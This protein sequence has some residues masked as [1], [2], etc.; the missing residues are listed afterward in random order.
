MDDPDDPY[1]PDN[2]S[3]NWRLG[4]RS[5]GRSAA[6]AGAGRA[7]HRRN[8]R[9]RRSRVRPSANRKSAPMREQ[10]GCVA[11]GVE[12]LRRRGGVPEG[13]EAGHACQDGRV[14]PATGPYFKCPRR[15]SRPTARPATMARSMTVISMARSRRDRRPR[16]PLPLP[17]VMPGG[18]LAKIADMLT[19]FLR[20]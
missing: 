19:I 4:G 9:G 18:N 8:G 11:R 16:R 20:R 5:G 2:L 10:S 13:C 15:D 17:P 6:E 1:S 7:F 3:W 12:W 14:P